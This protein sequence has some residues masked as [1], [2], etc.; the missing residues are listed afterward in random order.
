MANITEKKR[1]ADSIAPYVLKYCL[2][3]GFDFP[4]A[5]ICQAC[6]ES[7]F[8]ESSL[9]DNFNYWGMKAG[10]DWKGTVI[11]KVTWEDSN[12]NGRKDANETRTARFRG[13]DSI[14]EGIKGYF[15][16]I[17]NT[18]NYVT[19]PG[20]LSAEDYL[21]RIATAGWATDAKYSTKLIALLRT[22]ELDFERY[23]LALKTRKGMFGNGRDRQK[24]LGNRY[25]AVQDLVNAMYTI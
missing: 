16:K 23:D 5:I 24:A 8:G 10:A 11:E 20:S 1:F 22:P 18:S 2:A 14:D 17:R 9:S 7:S 4:S 3:Y 21:Q 19:L 13:Y 15:D 12:K 25:R 6:H